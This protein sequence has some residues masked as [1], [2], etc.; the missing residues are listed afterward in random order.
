MLIENYFFDPKGKQSFNEKLSALRSHQL[1]SSK[2]CFSFGL[3]FINLRE[4]LFLIF[5]LY[6]CFIGTRFT[7]TR[8]SMWVPMENNTS[9]YMLSLLKK[10]GKYSTKSEK[11]KT[12]PRVPNT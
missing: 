12:T 5:L 6:K 4:R 1:F 9:T 3:F 8:K 7:R 11:S 2:L 10:A